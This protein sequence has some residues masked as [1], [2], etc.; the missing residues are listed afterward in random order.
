[1]N[2]KFFCY[3]FMSVKS[4]DQMVKETNILINATKQYNRKEAMLVFVY[5]P[6]TALHTVLS[7][8]DRRYIKISAQNVCLGKQGS[9]N[10][11][12]TLPMLKDLGIDMILTGS[13]DRRL[14]CGETDESA[15]EKYYTTLK[16][17]LK[18]TLCVGETNAETANDSANAVIR[19]QLEIGCSNIPEDAIY[20][21]AIIYQ[22]ERSIGENGMLIEKNDLFQKIEL[23]RNVLAQVQPNIPE[24]LPVFYGGK[25]DASEAVK[26]LKNDFLD[27]IF[28]DDRHWDLKCFIDVIHQV[29]S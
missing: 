18:A 28:I 10:G 5:L 22:P 4:I 1:M 2:Y 20:R 26:S 9:I 7:S 15:A 8:V 19:H 3:N 21:S 25:M 12:I 13:I 29:M 17:G 23:I 27:G 16:S 24:P 11:A 6:F 14:Y